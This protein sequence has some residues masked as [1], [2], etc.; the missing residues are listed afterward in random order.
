MKEGA[1]SVI[2]AARSMIS[3]EG[4]RYH[5]RTVHEGRYNKCAVCNNEYDI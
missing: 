1:T 3:K 5:N 2:S 4:L